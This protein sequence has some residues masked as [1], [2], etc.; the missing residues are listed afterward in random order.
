[1]LRFVFDCETNGLLH[2]LNTV[3]SL[4]LRDIDSGDVTSCSDHD[5][6]EP[7]VNGLYMLSQADLLVG[8]NV[9]NFDFRALKK[10]YNSFKL[11]KNCKINDTLI[12]SRV[13][14]PELE[15]VDEAKFS[16]IPRKYRGKHSLAA[17][18][19]RL[20]VKKIN[21]EGADKYEERW[22]IWSEEMQKYCEGDTLV[23]LELFKYFET[24]SL[25]SRCYDLEHDFARIMA[26]QEA[27][28]FPF[29]EKKAF[30]LVNELKK[31]RAEIDDQLQKV[32]PPISVE[33]FSE[34]TGKQLKTKI[35]K[36]N[37]ASRKQT[38][39]RLKEKYPE[40]TF[41]K[42]EKG[43]V[44]L[45]DDVLDDLGKKYSEAALLSKYQLLNKRL[46][47]IS[48][49]KEAWLKHSQKYHDGRIHG[50]VITNACVSGRC[51]HR[52]PNL[53]QTPRVGQPYGAECRALFYAPNGWRQ[54]GCDAS[55]LELR[56]LGAQLAYFDGGEYSKLVSTPGFDI[57]THNA[58]LFGIYDG[59]GKI[60]KR[61]RELAKTL[62]YAVLYGGGP[63]R[64]GSILDSSLKQQDRQEM[65]RET[66]DTFYRNL[67]AIKKLKDKVDEKVTQRGYLIGIDGRHLQIRS[68]HSALNQLL[69]STGSLCVKKATCILYE[70]CKDNHLRWGIHYAF[71]AH[72]HDEIQA[73]VKPQHVSLYKKLAVDC[74]RKSGEY[75]K[76]R[77]PLTGEVNEGKNWQETH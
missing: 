35:T 66:I 50:S 23:S 42:T 77:C 49:G 60:E 2:E 70:D 16:H 72:I 44:K 64:I 9:I 58:K 12:V 76:L 68:R 7:I 48:E 38:S 28:G 62:I 25:D 19:E 57:H 18:G 4:V 26:R 61:T 69:Q 53:A 27:F 67:P 13:L 41:D 20:N 5:G 21:F 65:G 30:A 39:E 3:H 34:K 55:G 71:V 31:Q 36:F 52:G 73:L 29:D 33:R 51:S 1:M 45:D 17:W 59:Q 75:F 22:D 32:F 37:P 10:V 63:N 14:W 15:P 11:K 24:Q 56:A 43:N 40:I 46:G 8:H 47:Q 74:F 54:V 6:Y